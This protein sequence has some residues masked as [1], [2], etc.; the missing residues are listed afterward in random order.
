MSEIEKKYLEATKN[1]LNNNLEIIKDPYNSKNIVL[2]YDDKSLLSRA[3][4]K[5]YIDNLKDNKLSEIIKFDDIGKEELK[6]KL[7]WLEEHSTVVLVSSTNFRLDNFRIRLNLHNAWIGCLEHNHLW[8]MKDEELENYADAITYR[9]P[10]YIELSNKLKEIADKSD[11]LL[12]ECNDWSILTVNWGFEDMKQNTWDY[13]WKRRWWG[14]PIWENFNEVLDFSKCNWELSIYAFPDDKLQMEFVKPFKI[15]IKNSLITCEDDNCPSSFR[16]ILDKIE[17][18]EEW[19]VMLRELW[20][21][22][23]TWI[24]REKP[25]C[26]VNAFERI[27]WFHI[28]LWKKHQIYRKK[29]HK[30]ISQRYHI[31]I[32]P[33]VK[34][35]TFDWK[36]FFENE[37]FTI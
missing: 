21:W 29:I 37:S 1:I 26:D 11:E 5:W 8:Y 3:L 14:F 35:M 12:V 9:T 22:L 30:D 15:K 20:F 16:A 34:S 25:L 18:D 4:S 28:S 10:Y 31:D 2:V 13:T 7:L 19:E 36:V 24:T 6:D 32:F 23:N 33:D 27:A 17:R